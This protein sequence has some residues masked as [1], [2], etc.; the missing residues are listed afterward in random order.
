MHGRARLRGNPG[1]RSGGCAPARDSFALF[2]RDGL[3]IHQRVFQDPRS[4][5]RVAE[6]LPPEAV[7]S[8]DGCQQNGPNRKGPKSQHRSKDGT[9]ETGFVRLTDVCLFAST[10]GDLAVYPVQEPL[11]RLVSPKRGRTFPKAHCQIV[12]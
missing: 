6:K 8:S 2:P 10:C 9:G 7:Q 12:E 5:E 3:N 1:C 11:I 4:P